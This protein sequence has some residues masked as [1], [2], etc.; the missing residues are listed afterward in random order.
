MT[1]VENGD[2]ECLCYS[3]FKTFRDKAK[4]Y[5]IAYNMHSSHHCLHELLSSYVPR[6]ESLHPWAHDRMSPV[7][8]SHLHKQSF[9]TTSLLDFI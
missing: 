1:V 6:S 4:S 5:Y 9:I 8:I 2:F 7:C 3:V